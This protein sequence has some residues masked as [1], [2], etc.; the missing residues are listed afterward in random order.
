MAPTEAKLG[1]LT[2]DKA[3]KLSNSNVPVIVSK[4]GALNDVTADV[5]LIERSPSIF[6]TVDGMV[7]VSNDTPVILTFPVTVEQSLNAL[8]SPGD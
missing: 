5:R 8:R 2:L 6:E 3:V 4:P 7:T 1:A